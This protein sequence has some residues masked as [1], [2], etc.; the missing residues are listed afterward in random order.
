MVSYYYFLRLRGIFS[1]T[2]SRKNTSWPRLPGGL[3]RSDPRAVPQ[4]GN[5]ERPSTVGVVA[6]QGHPRNQV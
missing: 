3:P 6:H 4:S 2:S 1:F 5:A